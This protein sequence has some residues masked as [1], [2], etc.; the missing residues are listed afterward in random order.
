VLHDTII[1]LR[2]FGWSVWGC[3]FGNPRRQCLLLLLR[4]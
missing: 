2:R 1:Y 3:S 4:L